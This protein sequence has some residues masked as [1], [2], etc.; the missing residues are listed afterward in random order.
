[1]AHLISNNLI[2][3]KFKSWFCSIL[4]MFITIIIYSESMINLLQDGNPVDITYFDFCKA[5]DSVP[6]ERLLSKL[7]CHNIIVSREKSMNGF[8]S[9]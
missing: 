7:Y 9:L 6:H 8:V 3:E 1:M 2:N 4:A 5:F